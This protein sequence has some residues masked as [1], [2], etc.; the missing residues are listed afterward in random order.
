MEPDLEYHG[1]IP[2]LPPNLKSGKSRDQKKKGR[3]G[4]VGIFINPDLLKSSE[5]S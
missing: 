3:F 2:L 4:C 1:E 5:T